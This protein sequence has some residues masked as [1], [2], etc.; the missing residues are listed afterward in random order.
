[1]NSEARCR[2]LDLVRRRS[3]ARREAKEISVGAKVDSAVRYTRVQGGRSA[4]ARAAIWPSGFRQRWQCLPAEI[5]SAIR[6]SSSP[7]RGRNPRADPPQLPA[8]GLDTRRGH[9]RARVSRTPMCSCGLKPVRPIQIADALEARRR[10]FHKQLPN[11][12]VTLAKPPVHL[13]G[14]IRRGIRV[15]LGK[16]PAVHSG[17]SRHSGN[18]PLRSHRN[19]RRESEMIPAERCAH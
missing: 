12:R 13:H 14:K 7:R 16:P 8:A 9:R 2:P 1:M 6:Q 15:T 10:H 17:Q 19:P 5:G 3:T 18:G 4:A 11:F